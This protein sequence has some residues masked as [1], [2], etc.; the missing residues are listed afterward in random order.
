MDTTLGQYLSKSRVEEAVPNLIE[1]INNSDGQTIAV[2]VEVMVDILKLMGVDDEL[3]FHKK[4]PVRQE[5]EEVEDHVNGSAKI[6]KEL[7]Y[8]LDHSDMQD[9]ELLLCILKRLKDKTSVDSGF[10]RGICSYV[11]SELIELNLM[12]RV[13]NIIAV[14]ECLFESWD[15]FS[16]DIVYPVPKYDIP[17]FIRPVV[18]IF[19]DQEK[20]F[21]HLPRWKDEYGQLRRNLLDHMIRKLE[22]YPFTY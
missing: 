8:P 9:S 20:A 17:K 16:G 19:I 4:K 22:H 12:N 1:N 14:M 3:L 18:N 10:N 5:V 6:L 7:G 21:N 13:D 11:R 15:K 2:E